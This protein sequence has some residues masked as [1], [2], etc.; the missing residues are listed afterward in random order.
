VVEGLLGEAVPATAIEVAA[1]RLNLA[2][3]L[4]DLLLA[5]PFLHAPLL[6]VRPIKRLG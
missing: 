5:E 4:E 2:E 6:P 1:I 3:D